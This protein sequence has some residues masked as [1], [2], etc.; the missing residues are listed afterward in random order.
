MYKSFRSFIFLYI[1]IFPIYKYFL[2]IS[3]EIFGGGGGNEF[4]RLAPKVRQPLGGPGHASQEN[5]EK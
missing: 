4:A 5:F 2:Y 1:S 3:L